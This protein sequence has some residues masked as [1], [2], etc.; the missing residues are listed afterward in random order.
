M[1]LSQGIN[2]DTTV[3]FYPLDSLG[4]E[5][6]EDSLN[7][8]PDTIQPSEQY[9][10]FQGHDLPA[11][12]ISPQEL[13]K[14]NNGWILPILL[15][16]IIVIATI[17]LVYRKK[18]LQ[19]IQASWSNHQANLLVR[20]GSLA[21]DWIT[22]GLG[23]VAL[24]TSSLFIY[25]V[26]N[27]ILNLPSPGS[28]SHLQFFLI[29]FACYSIYLI[30]KL[31]LIGISELIF[32]TR[33]VTNKYLL[34]SLIFNINIAIFLLPILIISTYTESAILLKITLIFIGIILIYKLF[35]SIIIGLSNTKFSIVYLF[36]Y[37][38]TVE[39]LP[40]LLVIKLTMNYYDLS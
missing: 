20:E 24:L 40:V 31:L 34:N 7:L 33:E 1:T 4:L 5:L 12:K 13:A 28:T 37:L 3:T 6:P 9:S 16:C 8:V 25:Q 38:C 21:S 10:F 36:L 30:F 39:I 17:Q 22:L 19:I 32:L 35:R 26:N 14:S 18:F 27:Q 15:F 23:I 2:I 29:I 11:G